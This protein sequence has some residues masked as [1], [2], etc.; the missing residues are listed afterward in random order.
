MPLP[1]ETTFCTI[2]VS[3]GVDTILTP[4]FVLEE[5]ANI[6]REY[7]L[8]ELDNSE[9]CLTL[10]VRR[11]VHIL[12]MERALRAPVIE[13]KRLAPP[14]PPPPRAETP[15][16]SLA[17]R[18]GFRAFFSSPR[19][20]KHQRTQSSVAALPTQKPVVPP[21]A[22]AP[23]KPRAETLAD[24][25]GGD[26][27]KVLAKTN[28]AIEPIAHLCE[29]KVL[30]IRYPMFAM[31]KKVPGPEGP[32][33]KQVAKITMQILR[34]P[35]LPG[36]AI[37]ELPGSIDETIKGIRY[38][39]WHENVY[40][41]GILTQVGGDCRVPRRRLLRLVGGHLLG[42]SEVTKKEV[43][44]IDLSQ[45]TEVID[46]NER[47]RGD[48]DPFGAQP[49]SFEIRFKNGDTISFSADKENDKLVWMDALRDLVGKVPPN[50]LWA[51]VYA[52]YQQEHK[53]E[54][55][56]QEKQRDRRKSSGPRK[57]SAARQSRAPSGA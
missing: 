53:Q 15:V 42:I 39:L 50:P 55:E 12:A 56:D 17:S 47:T 49:R 5:G 27:N 54:K 38:H 43:A 9:F 6:H 37:S 36:L 29:A 19:K 3:N 34:L 8:T 30:E 1:N 41:E 57:S 13:P 20:A 7:C 25:L 40:H 26:G 18:S 33:R 2:R 45:A 44:R 10:E 32:K 31:H 52:Q 51:R 48:Y 22:A 21:K 35:A 4:Y 28:I 16:S 23:S 24:Y 11:D 14:P 46:S